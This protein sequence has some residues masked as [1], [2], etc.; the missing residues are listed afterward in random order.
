MQHRYQSAEE[1]DTEA[2][3]KRDEQIGPCCTDLGKAELLLQEADQQCKHRRGEAVPDRSAE[4][5]RKAAR[6]QD[7]AP[8]NYAFRFFS[9]RDMLQPCP[10]LHHRNRRGAA[11]PAQVIELLQAV[12]VCPR[13]G[14]NPSRLCDYILVGKLHAQGDDGRDGKDVH[15]PRAVGPAHPHEGLFHAADLG[16]AVQ[17]Q[18][19]HIQQA[20]R[21]LCLIVFCESHDSLRPV[22]LFDQPYSIR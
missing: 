21:Q 17:Q 11:G 8:E 16:A 5:H 7:A 4:E 19:A 20:F 22:S 6:G 3:Q 14:V 1:A 9:F 12:K 10:Q 15:M 13:A 2:G 18:R